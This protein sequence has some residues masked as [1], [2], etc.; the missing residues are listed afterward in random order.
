MLS[1]TIQDAINEQIKNE[2]QSAYLYLAMAQHCESKNLSGFAR[3]LT[4]QWTEELEHAQK[5]I[6]YMNDRDGR[7]QL[8]AIEKPALEWASPLAVFKEVLAHE[9]KV[10]ALINGLYAVAIKE[11]DYATQ[12][13]LQWFIKEQVEEEK[14]ATMVIDQ[15]AMVGD[16]GTT[17]FFLDRQL[18]ARAK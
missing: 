15:L 7:V 12:I 2:I 18:G 8:A 6:G 10:T 3:W 5:L 4:M 1:K 9:Q 14:N 17:L 13:E 11:N 16:S